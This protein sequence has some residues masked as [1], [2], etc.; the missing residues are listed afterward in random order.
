MPAP[1]L[2]SPMGEGLGVRSSDTPLSR[3]RGRG[4]GWGLSDRNCFFLFFEEQPILIDVANHIFDIRLLEGDI[5]QPDTRAKPRHPFMRGQRVA[6]EGQ[7][8]RKSTRLN[9]S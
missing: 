3:A 9:S 5:A 2:P 7:R 8:D 1:A 6:R 4:R